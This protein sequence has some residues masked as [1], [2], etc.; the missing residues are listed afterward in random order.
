MDVAI[1]SDIHMR[2][3]YLDAITQEVTAVLAEFEQYAPEHAFVLGDLIEDGGSVAA[4]RENIRRVHSLL[5]E[6]DV[7]V[8]Y[9][10]G[11]HDVELLGKDELQTLLGQEQFYGVVEV[12]E[13]AF[14]YLDTAYDGLRGAMGRI[15]VEQLRWLETQLDALS[16]VILLAHHP[17][18]NFD[19]SEN[20]WFT[21]YPERAYLWERKE[22]LEAISQCDGVHGTIS[23]HIHQT[24]YTEFW[25]VP[26]VS[27]NAF[28]K[29]LPDR[30]LT[31]TYGLLS[32]GETPEISIQT[33]SDEG[34]SY[35]L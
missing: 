18:G 34:V 6:W 8:T 3:A 24:E 22:V 33:R 7:P 12:G 1:L 21:D 26:H 17:I 4:D 16:D 11:N 23:G 28:S 31:G 35:S 2:D 9:L 30:P 32:L 27:V 20:T 14:V 15:G 29:E 10:L 19:L 13:T 25:G 5:S